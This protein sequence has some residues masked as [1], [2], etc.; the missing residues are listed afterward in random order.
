MQYQFPSPL[1]ATGGSI[2]FEDD[3]EAIS[4]YLFPYPRE[5]NGGS[6]LGYS[7]HSRLRSRASVPFRGNWGFL[8]KKLHEEYLSNHQFPSPFEVTGVSYSGKDTLL[9]QVSSRFPS[10]FEVTGVS[11]RWKTRDEA[12]TYYVSV[13]SRGD[14]GVL[15]NTENTN[16]KKTLVSVP[17]R[18][19]WGSY[20]NENMIKIL[21]L[22]GFPYPP[23]VTGVSYPISCIGPSRRTT[24]YSLT[25]QLKLTLI[26]P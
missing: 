15:P 26:I 21:E 22:F 25:S 16:E 9:G 1:G 3:K 5:V 17:S 23:E 20:R 6:D 10:P 12:A 8:L 13:P 2:H 7:Y 19:E 4:Y 18:G 14:W 11:Y 24:R